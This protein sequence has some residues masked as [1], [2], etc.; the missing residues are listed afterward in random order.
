MVVMGI[1]YSHP[2]WRMKRRPHASLLMVTAGQGILPLLMGGEAG[3]V[4]GGQLQGA[5][6]A[7]VSCAAALII[8]G[9]YPLTQVY[10]IDEDRQRGDQSFAVRWGPEKVFASARWLVGLGM[11]NMLLIVHREDIFQ[12]FWTWLFPLAY[13]AFWGTLHVWKRRFYQQSTYQNHDWTFGLST[14]YAVAFWGFIA[15][16][17]AWRV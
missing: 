3:R 13:L 10:Q 6:L 8:T 14:A 12:R 9:F 15:V 17:Y 7:W 16:E 11:V 4:A 2:R 5:L 1:A